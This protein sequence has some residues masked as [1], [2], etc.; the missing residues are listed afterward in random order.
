MA[1]TSLVFIYRNSSGIIGDVLLVAT[2]EENLYERTKHFT[3]QLPPTM[4]IAGELRSEVEK[5]LEPGNL[6]PRN[7]LE[8]QSFA[9]NLPEMFQHFSNI[10]FQHVS[11]VMEQIKLLDTS[12]SIRSLL[13]YSWSYS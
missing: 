8:V 4:S 3:R 11:P 10:S 5:V 13:Q 6:V 7:F 2:G 1:R 12:F 9:E